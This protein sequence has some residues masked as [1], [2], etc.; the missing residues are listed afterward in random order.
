MSELAAAMDDISHVDRHVLADIARTTLRRVT[1]ETGGTHLAVDSTQTEGVPGWRLTVGSP[2]TYATPAGPATRAQGWKLHISATPLSAPLVLARAVRVLGH[3]RCPFKYATTVDELAR[4]VG[5]NQNRGSVGKFITVYPPDDEAAVEIA[6]AL[7]RATYGL[8][9]PPILSDRAYRPGG[10]VH[11]RFGVFSVP[12]V[13]DNDGYYA[14]RLVAPDGTHETDERKAWYSPP[15]WASCPFDSGRAPVRTTAPEAVLLAGRFVVREAIRHGARGGVFLAEDRTTGAQVVIKRARPHLGAWLDGR[16]ERDQMRH[17]ARML[18]LFGPLGVT[19]RKVL[20]FEQDD[21]LFLAQERVE[22][23]VLNVWSNGAHGGRPARDRPDTVLSVLRRLTE[24]VATVHGRGYVLRDLTPGNVMVTAGGDCRLIDLEMAA[25]PGTPVSHAH[26]PGFAPPEQT[27]SARYGPALGVEADLYALGA[28]M[29]SAVTS[30]QPPYL[31]D[32]PAGSRSWDERVETVTLVASAGDPTATALSPL[33]LGLMRKDPAQ[34]W[35]LRRVRAFLDGIDAGRI[36]SSPRAGGFRL[37]AAEQDRLLHDGLAYSLR[38]MSPGADTAPSTHLWPSASALA[39][40]PCAVQYGSA[41]VIALWATLVGPAQASD[42]LAP[43]TRADL[44]AGL[45]KAANWTVRQLAREHRPSPGLYFGRAG[46]SVALYEAGRT[47]GDEGLRAAGL[48]AGLNLPTA[49]PNP[50]ICHG[51]AGTG[52]ALLHLWRASGDTRLRDLAEAC[53]DDL[54][55]AARQ[56]PETVTWPIPV[57]FASK[58]AGAEHYGFAHGVAGIAAYLLAA[59]IELGRDDCLE[60]AVLAGETL[61]AAAEYRGEA[62]WWASGPLDGEKLPHWC[63]GS[64]GIGTYLVRLYAATGEQ[65]FRDAARGAAVTVHDARLNSGTTACHGLAGDGQF[66]LDMADLL[67]EP[68]YH[69]QAEELA[70]VLWARAVRRDG[71]LV[72]PGENDAEISMGWNTGLAG[73]LDFLYR[74]RHGGPRRWMAETDD[75]VR[76]PRGGRA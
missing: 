18:D 10:L 23:T 53:A 1:N 39:A 54:L 69:E 30:S 41:G 57:D 58:L 47:L 55:K 16:D 34:R 62:A 43:E 19:T 33:V 45:R 76:A 17:E 44:T 5:R 60:T 75:D 27:D 68:A 9:G 48:E 51:T 3:R 40:D 14:S 24:L 2:W 6:E 72:V 67:G 66:L 22:G 56:T 8:P 20:L 13:L 64:S 36:G 71:L 63:S 46:I 4:L 59:G 35:D 31:K 28:T 15:A 37:E 32:Q 12:G 65:R 11:Y 25:V 42:V 21:N 29:L 49:W 50:D 52:M 7:Y 38:T 61:V 73:V 74:L 70:A 26:T